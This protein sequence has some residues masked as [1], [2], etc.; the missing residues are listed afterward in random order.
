MRTFIILSAAVLFALSPTLADAQTDTATATYDSFR[1]GYQLCVSNASGSSDTV[2]VLEFD[3]PQVPTSVSA[4]AGWTV[5]T[6]T[7]NNFAFWS[8]TNNGIMP[9]QSQCGFDFKVKVRLS[10]PQTV[11]ATFCTSPPFPTCPQRIT[12]IASEAP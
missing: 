7:T 3:L 2:D 9:A 5:G 8:T 10:G 11:V 12:L 4:P 1:G 6:S